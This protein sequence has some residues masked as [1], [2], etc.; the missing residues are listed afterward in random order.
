MDPSDYCSFINLLLNESIDEFGNRLQDY[1]LMSTSYHDFSNEKDYHNLMGGLFA[2]LVRKYIIG[3][4]REAG[5]GRLDHVL[6]PFIGRGNN[7]IIL[8]YKV[9]KTTEQLETEALTG[10]KQI[11]IKK[12]DVVLKKYSYIQRVTKIA[13]AFC[14]KKIKLLY[15]VDSI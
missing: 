6:I 8:E 14:G 11:H 10:L 1:L 7:A 3:S 2:P 9:V 4:N 12:Y 5:Y 15:K 13:L